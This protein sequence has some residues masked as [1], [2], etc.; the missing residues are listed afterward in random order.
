MSDSSSYLHVNVSDDRETDSSEGSH[1]WEEI[2]Q[3]QEPQPQPLGGG[4]G[5]SVGGSQPSNADGDDESEG[6]MYAS[7]SSSDDWE[8]VQ[9]GADDGLRSENSKG[10]KV[11]FDLLPDMRLPLPA[12]APR[13]DGSSCASSITAATTARNEPT[14][15]RAE[16]AAVGTRGAARAGY[17]SEPSD[18][19]SIQETASS[20]YC[21][22]FNKL[23]M[24]ASRGGGDSCTT[25]YAVD[26]LTHSSD[27]TAISG[28][29][30]LNVDG[31]S[32]IRCKKCSLWNGRDKPIMVCETC[33]TALSA[34]PCTQVDKNFALRI[35][36]KFEGE[37]LAA[38]KREEK[39]RAMLF[40]S[41]TFSH[42][43][44]KAEVLI[45]D[46]NKVVHAAL[47]R[48]TTS[49]GDVIPVPDL[50]LQASD[51]IDH[52]DRAKQASIHASG[53]VD[54]VDRTKQH[55]SISLLYYSCPSAP[56]QEMRKGF[57]KGSVTLSPDVDGAFD[58][59]MI[60]NAPSR[61][62]PYR[63]SLF[64][65]REDKCEEENEFVGWIVLVVDES[66]VERSHR[67]TRVTAPSKAYPLITFRASLR[68]EEVVEKLYQRLRETCEDIFYTD[69]EASRRVNLD[70]PEASAKKLKR[71]DPDEPIVDPIPL[72]AASATGTSATGDTDL[73]VAEFLKGVDF[74]LEDRLPP[75]D[76]ATA[77]DPATRERES[78]PDASPLNRASSEDFQDL[79]VP[80]GVE[81]GLG[82]LALDGV[83][84]VLVTPPHIATL[85]DKFLVKKPFGWASLLKLPSS[86]HIGGETMRW[87]RVLRASDLG[88]QWVCVN[89][90]GLQVNAD[91]AYVRCWGVEGDAS[92]VPAS[93]VVFAGS[94]S[95]HVHVADVAKAAHLDFS[96]KKMWFLDMCAADARGTLGKFHTLS[97][98][99]HALLDDMIA[100]V[101]SMGLS[102]LKMEWRVEFVGEV[103]CGPTDWLSTAVAALLDPSIGLWKPSGWNDKV[104]EVNPESRTYRR[105]KDDCFHWRFS[106][107]A[108]APLAGSWEEE[109]GTYYRFLG[110]IIGKALAEGR[111][112]NCHLEPYIFKHLVG[113]PVALRDVMEVDPTFYQ[114]IDFL[115]TYAAGGND[116][117]MLCLDFTTTHGC[118]QGMDPIELVSGGATLSVTNEN[119]PDYLS[120][121]VKHRLFGFAKLQISSLLFG[122]LDVIP[123]HLLGV[124]APSELELLLCGAP[125]IDVEDWKVHTEYDCADA[126][127]AGGADSP[128]SQ[129]FWQIVEAYDSVDRARLLQFVTGTSA[130]PTGG[131]AALRG[132]HSHSGS[133]TTDAN[134]DHHKAHKFTLRVV[135]GKSPLLF[136]RADRSRNRL[137]LPLCGSLSEL[138][139]KL[140][141]AMRPSVK[142]AFGFF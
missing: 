86:F 18:L 94:T 33:N 100:Q 32:N 11:V 90:R 70:E 58:S 50:L 87:V 26:D 115:Q 44:Q 127:T 41:P 111:E 55:A 103:L 82:F 21:G 93:H 31:S 61:A 141:I 19:E 133:S 53:T 6:A 69:W 91:G 119:L 89:E 101:M 48:S 117:S 52:F 79:L 8:D 20:S 47:Q 96:S 78:S 73:D 108:V 134:V 64:P 37:A 136:P 97:V 126:A 80:Q 3:Q 71:G 124:L 138:L 105:A 49:K 92:L 81:P 68:R 4:D 142:P 77:A 27:T 140:A 14:T 22:R 45:E 46:I 39:K 62:P 12:A 131:F 88:F 84:P 36:Q 112:L 5:G 104:M 34:N 102:E 122:V 85:G 95:T 30:C 43:F 24:S 137:D 135:D 72:N 23:T 116:V 113:S 40:S 25:S 54:H 114:G 106:P 125:E 110:R 66:P 74:T 67:C 107:T 1:G 51:V 120:A 132:R 109:C 38:L 76:L 28:F 56:Y 7:E 29:S 130:I 17:R 99:R 9:D 123:E 121:L 65:I 42:T 10:N 63:S 35:Q 15:G 75:G 57:E 128:V 60:Q 59:A 83:L 16:A 129:W 13:W 2:Q 98:R 139:T 118:A